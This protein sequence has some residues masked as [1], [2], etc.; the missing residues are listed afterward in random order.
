[1]GILNVT[2]DSFSDGGLHFDPVEA[3]GWGSRL[4]EQGA[5]II[6]VGGESTRPGAEPVAAEEELRR[7]LPV[8]AGLAELGIP[9]SIDT[10]KSVVARAALEAGAKIVND[11]SGLRDPEMAS[12]V[13]GA[14][15]TVCI[16]HMQGSPRTMQVAPTYS[17]VVD[18]VLGFLLGQA[19]AAQEA[20]IQE[21]SIW[22]DPGIGFGKTLEQNLDL[23]VSLGKFAELG[24][25][26]LVGVSRKSFIGALSGVDDPAERLGGSIAC[27]LFAVSRGA[28]ILRVHDVK[29]TVQALAVWEALA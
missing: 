14:G 16:M 23:L 27:G 21:D 9:V 10:Q 22:L 19:R 7:T 26:I 2:P 24:H 18:E 1:M 11:V 6:D 29:Q 20:G 12:V 25:P 3:I 4:V 17:N 15:A 13:A 8:V 5:D 28:R